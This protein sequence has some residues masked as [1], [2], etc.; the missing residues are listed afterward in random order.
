MASAA[1]ILNLPRPPGNLFQFANQDLFESCADW[2]KDNGVLLYEGTRTHASTGFEGHL[3]I[4]GIAKE[5]MA[6]YINEK[7]RHGL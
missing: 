4:A 7:R 5:Q 1:P 6:A 3:F 2:A